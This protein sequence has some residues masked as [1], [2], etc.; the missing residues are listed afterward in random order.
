MKKVKNVA[1]NKYLLNYCNFSTIYGIN[2][3]PTDSDIDKRNY[4]TDVNCCI[5]A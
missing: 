4:F 5:F 1:G 2:V 3:I